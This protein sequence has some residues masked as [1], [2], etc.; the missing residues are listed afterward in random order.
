MTR[1]VFSASVIKAKPCQPIIPPI[2]HAIIANAR[3]KSCIPFAMDCFGLSVREVGGGT[4]IFDTKKK[5]IFVGIPYKNITKQE[6]VIAIS[7]LW[8]TLWIDHPTCAF[9]LF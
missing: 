7:H 4:F 5:A 6:D 1:R 3:S 2:M 8:P 9:A